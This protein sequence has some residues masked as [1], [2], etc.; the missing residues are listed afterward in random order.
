MPKDKDKET[1][2]TV[3]KEAEKEAE[4]KQEEASE[5]PAETPKEPDSQTAEP[6]PP[7]SD[8]EKT[9]QEPEKAPENDATQEPE[10]PEPAPA[11][12]DE[13]LLAKAQVA[14]YKSGMNPAVVDD[15]VCLAMYDAKKAGGTI[16]E[17]AIAKALKG[18]MSRHPEWK[19]TEPDTKG[20]RVGAEPQNQ[21]QSK[22]DDIAKAFGNK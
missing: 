20:F 14:A 17:A 9:E 18:V 4:E 10:S 11:I 13:L 7:E 2:E 22:N 5:T 16:D 21:P 12:N 19:P 3:A 15:A 1:E 8:T 6:G